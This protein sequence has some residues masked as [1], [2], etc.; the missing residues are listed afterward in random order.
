MPYPEE[1]ATGE[2]LLALQK[3]EALKEFEGTIKVSDGPQKDPP[4]IVDVSR[5]S[6]LPKRVVAIDGS[7][8][9]TKVRNGFPGAEA[10][11]LMLAVV[12]IDVSKLAGIK[13]NEIPSPKVFNEMDRAAP[14]DAVLPGANI[15]DKNVPDD[16]PTAYFRRQVFTTL[17]GTLDDS[18]ETFLETLR[19]I[20]KPAENVRCPYEDCSLSNGAGV[21]IHQCGCNLKRE[22]YETDALRMHERFNELGSNGEVHGEVRHVLE[23]LSLVNILRYFE[24]DERISYLKDT[25]FVL[26]GPLAVFGQ[27]ARIA[28]FVRD[29]II[30]ISKKALEKNGVPPLII[31][32]EK[33]GLYVNHFADLDWSEEG[34]EK[35]RFDPSTVLI[36][37]AKYINRN[38]VFRPEEAKPSG[39]D[40]YFGRKVF[41]KT[42]D[43]NHAVLN[44]AMT[45]EFSADFHN[46]TSGAFPR[47]GDALN[48]L[49]HL[50][51]YLYTDGFMPL[52]RAHAHAAIPLKRGSAILNSLLQTG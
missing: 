25:A 33:S 14:H 9:T 8:V 49:D 31:G 19:A 27:P 34:A 16:T 36:P 39:Q 44:F 20:S 17:G 11:L 52:V 28:P 43:R 5:T 21:G 38:I 22:L 7:T 1:I 37:D 45:N 24:A 18:H 4:P 12:F 30:R 2:S 15:V 13:S 26:D 10:T 35:G 51:T 40:T 41:Y 48:I 6:W 3:S 50:S 47:L 23:V 46:T 29:E 42:K 32:V